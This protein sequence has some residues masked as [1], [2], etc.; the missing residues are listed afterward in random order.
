MQVDHI[1]L[2][3]DKSQD[4]EAQKVHCNLQKVIY[5][6]WYII[7]LIQQY[8]PF[9]FFWHSTRWWQSKDDKGLMVPGLEELIVEDWSIEY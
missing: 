3:L 7:L 2:S 6:E 8:I 5:L 9:F 4:F 1:I